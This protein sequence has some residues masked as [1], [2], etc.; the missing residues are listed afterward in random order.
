V[1]VPAPALGVV[2][3]RRYRLHPDGFETLLGLFEERLVAGQEQAGI[4][5]GPVLVDEDEPD[6]FVWWR[7]FEDMA[8][9]RRA[10]ESFYLGPVWAE[11][12]DRANATMI[13]SDDVLLLRPTRGTTPAMPVLD[14][15]VVV[16]TGILREVDPAALRSLGPDLRAA[17][18]PALG[19]EAQIWVSE[20]A[21]N[22]FPM[23]PVRREPSV[24]WSATFASAAE[25]ADRLG[26][27]GPVLTE[28]L[29]GA[30]PSLEVEQLDLRP[31]RGG[32]AMLRP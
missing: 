30:G 6:S 3:L 1:N 2:E 16:A 7:A 12:R 10:L 9:R 23:L 24:V 20:P 17:L 4:V 22:S 32:T 5:V 15:D 27:V 29:A 26:A 18:E 13:D 25:R 19:T 31:A 14:R 21:E 28:V 11:Y 8:S